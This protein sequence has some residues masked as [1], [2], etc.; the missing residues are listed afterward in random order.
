MIDI[1]DS[2]SINDND[3]HIE[4]VQASGPGGQNVNK[5]ATQAQ[6]R[7]NTYASSLPDDVRA[8]LWKIAGKRLTEDRMLIIQARRFR[9]QEQNRLD[10]IER[11]RR[12]IREACVEPKERRKT[13]PTLASKHRRL[14][15]KRR[16]SEIKRLR[17]TSASHED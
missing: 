6:L 3:Y 11:L 2:I 7:F 4:F 15:K 9:S 13:R 10:A 5:L 12:L 14:A 8:R 1:T 17:R 16:H